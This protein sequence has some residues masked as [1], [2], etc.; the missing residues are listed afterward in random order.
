MGNLPPIPA[1]VHGIIG[2]IVVKLI[3]DLTDPDPESLGA[4]LWG[5][6]DPFAREIH[7]RS[8]VPLDVQWA[9]LEHEWAHAAFWDV[10]LELDEKVEE[11]V[12]DALG[13]ARICSL[14]VGGYWHLP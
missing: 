12:C 7:I 3:P 1:I 13:A 9:T 14:R 11:S 6:W 5:Y 8:T 10:G 2:P 4:P